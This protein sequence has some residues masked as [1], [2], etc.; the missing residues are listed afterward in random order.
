LRLSPTKIGRPTSHM[1]QMDQD[2]EGVYLTLRI[3]ILDRA[4]ARALD[5][6]HPSLTVLT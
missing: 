2:K 1:I 3:L 4:P 6:F 5:P